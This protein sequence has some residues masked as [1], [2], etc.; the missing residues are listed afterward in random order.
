MIQNVTTY[1]IGA[2][3]LRVM[4]GDIAECATDAVVNAANAMLAGGSGVDGAIHAGAG[5]A[6]PPAC[7]AIIAARG[8]VEAGSAVITPGFGLPARFII[9][10]VGPIWRGGSHGEPE[11]LASAYRA[12]L[13]LCREHALQTVSFP[14][15][16]CGAYGYPVELAAPIALAE[17]AGGLREGAVHAAWMVLYSPAAYQTWLGIARQIL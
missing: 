16:S 5:P 14:A 10:A 15:L 3:E 11:Q 1:S 12:S 17:L 4:Q 2:G 8:L 13:A 9:H 6:L 7:R